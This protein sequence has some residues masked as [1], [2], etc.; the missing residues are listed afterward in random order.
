MELNLFCFIFTSNQNRPVKNGNLVLVVLAGLSPPRPDIDSYLNDLGFCYFLFKWARTEPCTQYL[1]KLVRMDLH[2]CLL[3]D[4]LV[5]SPTKLLTTTS[6]YYSGEVN[7]LIDR[8]VLGDQPHILL[9]LLESFALSTSYKRVSSLA[10]LPIKLPAPWG[11]DGSRTHNC[12]LWYCAL[13]LK[14]ISYPKILDGQSVITLHLSCQLVGGCSRSLPQWGNSSWSISSF[15]R[16]T[17]DPPS[18]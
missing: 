2:H 1:T 17:A 12:E 7:R 10:A 4:C 9:T 16:H 15:Q 13:K 8:S 14:C 11:Q 3:A 5:F 6:S 18:Q